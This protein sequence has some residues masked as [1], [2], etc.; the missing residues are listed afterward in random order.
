[1]KIKINIEKKYAYVCFCLVGIILLLVLV[2]AI[3]PEVIGH[4]INEISGLE[5][6]VNTLISEAS[7]GIN[8]EVT[9][10]T[11]CVFQNPCTEGR[12]RAVVAEKVKC[13]KPVLT[14]S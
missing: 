3:G 4:S 1:M 5:V 10:K 9:G 7:V 6:E 14:C 8:C 13:C 12:L 11:D 2:G